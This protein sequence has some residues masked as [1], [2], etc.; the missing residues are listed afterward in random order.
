MYNQ[1]WANE[2][3]INNDHML[4]T[5][6]VLMLIFYKATYLLT[7]ITCQQRTLGSQENT[8][9]INVNYTSTIEQLNWTMA[10]LGKAFN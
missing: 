1:T 2:H 8:D 3:C 5:T 6:I 4:T 9:L 7:T 10:L